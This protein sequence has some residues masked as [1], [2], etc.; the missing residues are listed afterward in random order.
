MLG[1]M[2][3]FIKDSAKI[4]I[5]NSNY[6]QHEGVQ[7]FE[8]VAIDFVDQVYNI[9][10]GFEP[11]SSFKMLVLTKHAETE[12][13]SNHT[14]FT[15]VA[16]PYYW[17]MD[18]MYDGSASIHDG[19]LWANTIFFGALTLEMSTEWIKDRLGVKEVA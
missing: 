12:N 2:N 6:F 11:G 16:N 5:K 19:E 15:V 17:T 14:A 1:Y 7:D 10:D 4:A 3:D 9:I 18:A 8:I 13:L